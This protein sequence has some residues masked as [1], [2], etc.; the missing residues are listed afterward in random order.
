MQKKVN[1]TEIN[2]I[3]SDYCEVPWFRRSSIVSAMTWG[4]VLLFPPLIVVACIIC[5][6]GDVYYNA[7]TKD[8]SLKKRSVA[9]KVAAIIILIIASVI[10]YAILTR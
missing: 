8:G 1:E 2:Q 10:W 5:I 3:Y 9:D 7:F 4:G 6:T